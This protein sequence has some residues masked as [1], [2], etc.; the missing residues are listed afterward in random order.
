MGLREEILRK[1]KEEIETDPTGVGYAGKTDEEIAI[2]LSNPINRDKVITETYSSPMSRIIAGLAF[3]PNNAEVQ[4]VIDSREFV[5][6][7][8]DVE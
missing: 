3:A 7:I 1:I 2:L 4:D 6:E 8:G 5:A